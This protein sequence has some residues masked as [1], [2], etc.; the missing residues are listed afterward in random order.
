MA[1]G[2]KLFAPGM[3]TVALVVVTLEG[4][5]LPTRMEME[6]QLEVEGDPVVKP[7]WVTLIE[8]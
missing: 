1:G 2:L 8:I 3:G 6:G 4:R 7:R 5:W